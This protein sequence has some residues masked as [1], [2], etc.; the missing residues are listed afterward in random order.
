MAERAPRQREAAPGLDSYDPGSKEIKS[1]S[2]ARVDGKKNEDSPPRRRRSRGRRKPNRR[3]SA[4]SAPSV[5][6]FMLVHDDPQG[7]Q[8][9]VLEESNGGR[10]SQ[11]EEQKGR[12]SHHIVEHFVA[13]DEDR[14]IVGN[15]YLGRVQN[16][17][18]SMEAA[19]I[20][21]GKGR[22][23]V[24]YAGEVNWS[25]LGHKDGQPRK[26]ESVLSSGQSVLVQ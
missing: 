5:D 8:I 15:V 13:R 16:V 10:S 18:P 12:P 7:I 11:N 2:G 17:L 9:A 4:R 19:F 20:D 24:L 21:I 22:N 14:S 25:A 1:G 23:A 26:I 6:R 3:R